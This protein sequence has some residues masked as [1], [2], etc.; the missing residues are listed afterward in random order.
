M[1]PAL[2]RP[3]QTGKHLCVARSSVMETGVLG[4]G[5]E[6]HGRRVTLRPLAESD[7]DAWSEIRFRCRSWL[8]PWEP[9]PAGAP[10]VVDDRPGFYARCRARDRER[11]SGSG[12]GFGIFLGDRLCGEVTLSSIQ[13][14]PFQSGYVGYW[15]DEAMAGMGLAPEATVVV[16]RFAFEVLGLHRV[17]IAIVPRNAKSIRVAEKLGVRHEG[18]SAG[19]LEI[20]GMWEDHLRYAMTVEEWTSRR[21]EL[22]HRW[23][24]SD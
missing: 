3:P 18:V 1:L 11:Q 12:Y 10:E 21:E 13:R 19:F 14:G 23:L 22:G 16:I 6:L 2:R 4:G 9:R 5:L 17:E 8:L 15:V 7:Y 20:N 24:D